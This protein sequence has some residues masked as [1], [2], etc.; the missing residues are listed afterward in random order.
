MSPDELHDLVMLLKNRL[1]SREIKI[2]EG[3]R[4]HASLDNRAPLRSSEYVIRSLH[5]QAGQDRGHD[6]DSAFSAF[7]HLGTIS[8]SL[9]IRYILLYIKETTA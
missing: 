3:S 6:P 9:F 4:V 5:V 7:V 2:P 8:Y 1:A